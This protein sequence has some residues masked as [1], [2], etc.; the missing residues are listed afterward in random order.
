MTI[1]GGEQVHFK[2]MYW[3]SII[4]CVVILKGYPSFRLY[5]CI[6]LAPK[7]SDTTVDIHF[8]RGIL[9]RVIHLLFIQTAN[10]HV[11]WALYTSL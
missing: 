8:D 5:T 11:P 10:K 7:T 9:E 4:F 3:H 6:L 1:C 2:T